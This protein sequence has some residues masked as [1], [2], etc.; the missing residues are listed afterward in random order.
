MYGPHQSLRQTVEMRSTTGGFV[1]ELGPAPSRGWINTVPLSSSQNTLSKRSSTARSKR[2]VNADVYVKEYTKKRNLILELLV[3][4]V[5]FFLSRLYLSFSRT[6]NKFNLFL[7]AV[8]IEFLI[9]WHN[10]SSRP[11]LAIPGEDLIAAR[12]AKAVA[13]RVWRDNARLAWDISPNLAV[14]LPVR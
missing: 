12:R 13:D 2:P 10:P 5:T 7:K 8:E 4:N 3:S 1:G 6:L 14:F 9:I 11:E